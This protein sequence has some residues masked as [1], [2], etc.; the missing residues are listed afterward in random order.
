MNSLVGYGVSSDSDSEVEKGFSKYLDDE[1]GAGSKVRNFLLES[2]SASSDSGSEES[3]E[4]ASLPTHHQTSAPTATPAGHLQGSVNS[5]KLPPPPL[6]ACTDSSVF[7]NPFK[8]Q[9]DQRLN[10][11]QKHVPLTMHA[12][13]SQIGGKRICVAYRKD[14]RCRFGIRCKFA[15][16]SDLQTSVIPTDIDPPLNEPRLLST[17]VD[18]CVGQSQISQQETDE[19]DSKGKV[20]KRRVG[21]SDTLI[22]PKRAM[23]QFAKQRDKG[24]FS[25]P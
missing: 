22:P 21:L 18:S 19:E 9:A 1:P 20:K 13:P 4:D 7:T 10:A 17:Q 16:D 24:R 6:D 25:V 11:L 2:G 3:A 12:K 23:K 5:S 15:H 14:G 8:A